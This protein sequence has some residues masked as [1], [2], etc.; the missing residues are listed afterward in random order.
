MALLIL[1]IDKFLGEDD[2]CDGHLPAKL[3]QSFVAAVVEISVIS[4]VVC[5]TV[6]I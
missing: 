5:R 6:Q 4:P 1:T 3:K 2:S